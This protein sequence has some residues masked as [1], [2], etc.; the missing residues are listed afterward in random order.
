MKLLSKKSLVLSSII[1]SILFATS[2]LVS[3]STY[4]DG[5]YIQSRCESLLGLTSWDCGVDI[6]D[7]ASL[8][9]G[10]WTIAANVATDIT[11]IAAYLVL[12]FVIYGGYLYMFSSGDAGKAANGKKTLFHAFVGLAI[13]MAA[14]IIVGSIR[15]AL[16]GGSG[17]I[18]N[19][20]SESGCVDANQM[21][22]NLIQW[23]IGIAGVI[24]A[25][26]LIYGGILFMTSSGDVAKAKQA[27][28]AIL[29]AVI[30]LIIVALAEIITAFVSNII[31]ENTAYLQQNNTTISKEITQNEKVY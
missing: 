28:N 3:H 29:Y 21:V 23:V 2:L 11:I 19:C 10:V 4:A 7:E 18:G 30:G 27:K 16:V 22:T 6:R 24:A 12:G 17:N 15:I 31:R 20:F 13:V 9:T 26:F 14:Y 1:V 8:K 5:A 25:I